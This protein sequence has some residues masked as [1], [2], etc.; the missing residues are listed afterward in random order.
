MIPK[1]TVDL[2]LFL[3]LSWWLWFISKTKDVV[4]S[5][6]YLEN[7][8]NFEVF[9]LGLFL[10]FMDQKCKFIYLQDFSRYYY[11]VLDG[12]ELVLMGSIC[13]QELVW[14]ARGICVL[15]VFLPEGVGRCRIRSWSFGFKRIQFGFAMR[16]RLFW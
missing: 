15:S 4:E 7:W 6:T 10:V 8:V 9:D 16:S 11:F 1:I 3:V 2:G 12:R 5:S 14:A 13:L